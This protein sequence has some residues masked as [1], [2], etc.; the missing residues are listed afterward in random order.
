MRSINII[1]T[2]HFDNVNDNLTSDNLLEYSLEKKIDLIMVECPVDAFE[3]FK[4]EMSN[5]RSDNCLEVNFINKMIDKDDNVIVRPFDMKGINEYKDYR[6]EKHL[7]EIFELLELNISDNSIREFVDIHNLIEHIHSTSTF[8]HINSSAY[9]FLQ[10]KKNNLWRNEVI[11]FLEKNNKK[12]KGILW[13]Y[14]EVHER[15]E[16]EMV[17]NILEDSKGFSNV[18]VLVGCAHRATIS[19]LLSD[20]KDIIS[21]NKYWE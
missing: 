21:L 16:R 3:I 15:R 13:E 12:Y 10:T 19:G 17:Y 11:N 9:D 5:P 18:M 2:H 8:K 1:G 14:L 6:S 7:V 20:H 4:S